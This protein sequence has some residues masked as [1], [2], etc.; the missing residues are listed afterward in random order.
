MQAVITIGDKTT[1]GGIV[2][3]VDNTFVIQGKASHLQGMKHF[4]P[5]CKT[6]VTAIA[7]NNLVVI[8]GKAMIVA[9]DKTTCG[10]TFLPSQNLV[11]KTS[12]GMSGSK[13][14]NSFASTSQNSNNLTN[15]FSTEREKYINYYIPQNSTDI[16]ISHK[17]VIQPFDEGVQVLSGAVSYFLNYV[18]NDKNLFI[19]V[20]INAFP[21]SENGKV[22]P[23]GSVKVSREGKLLTTTKLTVGKGI[24]D[25]DKKKAPLG[26]CNITLP[27]PNLQL[28]EVELTLGYTVKPADSV[29]YVTPIPPYK[30]YTFK[31]NSAAKRVN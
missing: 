14:S 9:G 4:C 5:K 7:S 8:N 26:S 21:L 10:A 17:A 3:E 1:H 18:L 11:G 24:W 27:E 16:F 20:S 23:Y 28:V 6:I 30:K 29:G 31:L 2:T 19:S 22:L 12:G 15:S 25:T 13:S